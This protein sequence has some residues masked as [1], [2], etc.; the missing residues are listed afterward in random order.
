MLP[1]RVLKR[2]AAAHP[3]PRGFPGLVVAG[4]RH[5][6]GPECPEPEEPLQVF[7]AGR[8]VG[9]I[10]R[11]PVLDKERGSL[12]FGQYP[13]DSLGI[14]GGLNLYLYAGNDPI[15]EIDPSGMASM[16]SGTECSDQTIAATFSLN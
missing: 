1:D 10:D 14:E 16:A 9:G 15:F 4:L 2:H 12:A 7:P 13:E 6:D 5:G 3:G 8:V 11:A